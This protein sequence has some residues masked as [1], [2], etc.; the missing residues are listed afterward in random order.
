MARRTGRKK[1]KLY[2]VTL[3][4]VCPGLG[5]LYLGRWLKGLIF[6][7][8]ALVSLWGMSEP[9]RIAWE[10]Y[11]AVFSDPSVLLNGGGMDLD[12]DM[13]SVL[14]RVF[15]WGVL[16]TV[17]FFWALVESFLIAR[18]SQKESQANEGQ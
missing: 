15:L 17:I 18:K 10:F 11:S 4:L 9:L 16:F 6:I 3:S 12:V 2:A 13:F 5:H 14:R 1:S 7:G 8:I